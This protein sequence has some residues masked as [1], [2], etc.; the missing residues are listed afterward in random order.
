MTRYPTSTNFYYAH[1][2]II[3]ITCYSLDSKDSTSHQSSPAVFLQVSEFVGLTEL[4]YA[5][6]HGMD[7]MGPAQP[8]S[9]DQT[10]CNMSIDKQVMVLQ[11]RSILV[12]PCDAMSCSLFWD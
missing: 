6:S 11:D 10:K 2:L 1:S 5:G 9:K 8:N 3:E 4:Y 7:I 12:E